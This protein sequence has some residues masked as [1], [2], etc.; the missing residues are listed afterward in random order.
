M[1][2]DL[3][4]FWKEE[5]EKKRSFK[6][7]NIIDCI[8]I[9]SRVYWYS[10]FNFPL[11]GIAMSILICGKLILRF[12]MTPKELFEWQQ[13]RLCKEKFIVCRHCCWFCVKPG[14]GR[15]SA[16]MQQNFYLRDSQ[17]R[18]GEENICR[19]RCKIVFVN[20]PGRNNTA[21]NRIHWSTFPF[22]I[23]I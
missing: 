23:S 16:E 5:V 18:H 21:I 19:Y 6:C 1:V 15:G 7:K 20:R 14:G 22:N 10:N 3:I 4:S 13:L 8:V 2:I 12:I 11:Y 9:F 17:F